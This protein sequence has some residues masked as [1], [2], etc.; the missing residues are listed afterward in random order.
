MALIASDCDATRTHQHQMALI[1][2]D[3]APVQRESKRIEKRDDK[4][5]FDSYANIEI[6]ETMLKDQPRT[7]A[8]RCAPD[9][10]VI[11]PHPPVPLLGVS[12]GINRGCRQNDS[13]VNPVPPKRLTRRTNR[14]RLPPAHLARRDAMMN[15]PALF[16]D[17]VVI[18]VGCGTGV[19]SIFAARCALTRNS[20]S[21]HQPALTRKSHSTHQPG[22][23]A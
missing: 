9:E 3:R 13:L 21:T 17:A 1:T 11:L 2:S 14:P 16:K 5:Y 6:H 22:C 12:I 10:I 23:F 8:Y 19:L 20:H 7:T 18:D 15:N 4:Y